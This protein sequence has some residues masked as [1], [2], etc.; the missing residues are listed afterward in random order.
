MIIEKVLLT[1]QPTPQ[2]QALGNPDRFETFSPSVPLPPIEC[3]L[4]LTSKQLRAETRDCLTRI[5]VPLELIYSF[6][7]TAC[8]STP[9]SID[10]GTTRL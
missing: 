6:K 1:S 9:G 3:P 5:N 4:L 8:F 2:P 7:P 10:P